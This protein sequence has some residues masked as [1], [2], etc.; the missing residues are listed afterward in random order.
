M[1]IM[2]FSYDSGIAWFH[3]DKTSPIC[4]NIFRFIYHCKKFYLG[5][6]INDSQNGDSYE[7]RNSQP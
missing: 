3:F 1:F 2:K 7:N 5:L 6:G 4:Q